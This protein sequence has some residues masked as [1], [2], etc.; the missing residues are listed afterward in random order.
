M[1]FC[2]DIADG[3]P[4]NAYAEHADTD[5][6]GIDADADID[7]DTATDSDADDA[8]AN[9]DSATAT[10]PA[11]MSSSTLPNPAGEG[12][13]A[14]VIRLNHKGNRQLIFESWGMGGRAN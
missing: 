3:N 8:D 9:A 12:G 11:D 6:A 1:F 7:A 13:Y 10:D 2:G 5:D 4:A 14:S